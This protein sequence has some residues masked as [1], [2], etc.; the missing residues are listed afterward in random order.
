MVLTHSDDVYAGNRVWMEGRRRD[1]RCKD[2]LPGAIHISHADGTLRTDQ[3][4]IVVRA[5]EGDLLSLRSH[6]NLLSV[7]SG[8]PAVLFRT[9]ETEVALTP[10]EVD[11][12]VLRSLTPDQFTAICNAVGALWEMRA[13]WYD[14]DRGQAVGRI[15]D[16]YLPMPGPDF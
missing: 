9:P 6:S 5:H 14:V 10:E 4:G 12:L 13:H 15:S 1:P 2:V 7:V 16:R 8:E 3:L 11:R